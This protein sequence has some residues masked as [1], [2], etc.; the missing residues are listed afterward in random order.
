[1][2]VWTFGLCK[3][4]KTRIEGSFVQLLGSRF[5]CE[6]V[7]CFHTYVK[8]VF[9]YGGWEPPSGEYPLEENSAKSAEICW[10]YV[11]K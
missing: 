7:K 3:A 1:M 8:H 5:H 10:N 9:Q 6:F 2:Y 4:F 11:Q